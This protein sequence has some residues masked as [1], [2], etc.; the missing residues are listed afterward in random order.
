MKSF[1]RDQ[2]QKAM[3]LADLQYNM[4]MQLNNVRDA[5]KAIADFDERPISQTIYADAAERTAL[6]NEHNRQ[7]AIYK[8]M[9][10]AYA[11]RLATMVDGVIEHLTGLHPYAQAAGLKVIPEPIKEAA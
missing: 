8:E 6:V 7:L 4:Q 2:V 3:D 11:L 1:I 10:D 5:R 9:V